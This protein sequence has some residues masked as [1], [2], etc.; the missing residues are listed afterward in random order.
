[1]RLAA[2]L[3]SLSE[4]GVRGGETSRAHGSPRGDAD[5]RCLPAGRSSGTEL[6]LDRKNKRAAAVFTNA[7]RQLPSFAIPNYSTGRAAAALSKDPAMNY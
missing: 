1:M 3:T 6:I 7:S 2:A 5:M 4:L